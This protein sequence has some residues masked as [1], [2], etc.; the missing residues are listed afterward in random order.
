MAHAYQRPTL[1]AGNIIYLYGLLARELG[2]GK[3]TF[4]TRV[5]EALATD[6]MTAPDLGFDSTRELL[7]A[8]GEDVVRLTAFKG[9]RLYATLVAHP[10]WDE[11]L[12]ASA[13]KAAEAKGARGGKPWK[14][15]KAGKSSKPVRPLR[16]KREGPEE[17]APAGKEPAGTT[18]D[19]RTAPVVPVGET[20]A[21]P[22]PAPLGTA[23]P[24]LQNAR[25]SLE[26][27]EEGERVEEAGGQG[28]VVEDAPAGPVEDGRKPAISLTVTYDPYSGIEGESTLE[29]DPDAIKRLHRESSAAAPEPATTMDGHRRPTRPASP[30]SGRPRSPMSPIS[31]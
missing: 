24:G 6:R 15:K 27:D 29:S 22:A 28:P 12:S 25:F 10:D 5:E 3:Q 17:D 21:E 7:E 14:R 1:S 9:G 31:R 20:P 16:V 23:E 26:F 11:A 13:E 19:I 30:R 4:S 18:P 8:M 2:C